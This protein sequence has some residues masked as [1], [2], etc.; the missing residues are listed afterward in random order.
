MRKL[1]L[2]FFA[3]LSFSFG[4]AQYTVISDD[5]SYVPTSTNALLEVHSVNGNKGILV[6]RL[7][8]V[9]RTAIITAG[10]TDQSLLVYDTDTK[11]FWF[12]DGTAWVEMATGGTVTDDQQLTLSNDTL[13]IEDGNWIYL[14][15]YMDNTDN[16]TLSLSGSNLSISNGNTITL[17]VDNDWVISGNN[18]Y[19]GVSGNVG[20]GTTNPTE[21]LDVSGNIRFS[22]SLMPNGNTGTSG[23]V[24]T[25]QGSGSPIWQSASNTLYNQVYQKFGTSS[26]TLS[27]STFVVLSNLTQTVTLIGPAKVLIMTDGGIQTTSTSPAGY[28]SVDVVLNQNGSWLPDGAFKRITAANNDG[29]VTQL[30]FWSMGVILDITT[31]GTYTWDVQS[32]LVGGSNATV[33]G[34]NTSVLEGS[35]YILVIYQ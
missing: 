4:Q 10:N 26:S 15:G 21:K 25:S 12:W 9:Q 32:R 20:I 17:P 1:G 24:L 11:T 31:A 23:Q 29:L 6:P 2:L 30:A 3:I 22:G 35:L 34:N 14:G 28:S 16:Q 33:N 5:S 13:Y 19:S 7:T 8:T 18:Q 27:S